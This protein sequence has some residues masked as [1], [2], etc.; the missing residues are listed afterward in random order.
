MV[1]LHIHTNYSDGAFTPSEAV[2]C[3]KNAGLSAIAITDH[4]I[5]DG[6]EE[7]LMS[8]Q[9][10]GVEVIPGIEL[11]SI[12][13]DGSEMHILGY[14]IDYKSAELNKKL[15]VLI[16]DR[17]DRGHKILQKL[18]ECGAELK[19]TSFLDNS[20]G[21]A[22]GRLHFAKA[23]VAEGIVKSTQDAFQQFLAQGKPA[24][25]AKHALS[26][27]QAIKLIA[28]TG[29]ISVMAHPYYAHYNDMQM[30]HSLVAS[31]LSGIEAY[32]SKHP[33]SSVKKFLA[34]AKELG[35]I[36]TGGSD[37]H[38]PL[39]NEPPIMGRIKVSYSIVEDLKKIKQI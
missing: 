5:V 19:D 13:P 11:S 31:G 26:S 9:E 12:A 15:K 10:N 7:A 6:I 4:D 35:L 3:A 23:L 2:I 36:V 24:Y 21:K 22:V 38:G 34:L 14:F 1:D 32:H 29:G 16:K 28:Q 17:L 33:E 20:G 27:E 25:V 18:K 39:K 37:C 30:M 8:G